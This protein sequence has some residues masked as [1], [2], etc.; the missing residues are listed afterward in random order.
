[1]VTLRIGLLGWLSAGR[2]SFPD[3]DAVADGDFLGADERT[4]SARSRCL[5][6]YRERMA[7]CALARGSGTGIVRV[8]EGAV[9][10]GVGGVGLA[11]DAVGVDLEQDGDAVPGAAGDL[12]GGHP[13]I[14]P[15]GDGGVAEVV[16]AAG[17]RGG[18]LGGGEHGGPG[19]VP[20]RAVR[21]VLEGAAAGG[22]E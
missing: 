17:E 8:V 14:E 2:G 11:V 1:M 9:D 21:A 10:A 6:V 22:A 19:G 16:G 20:D 4:H 15:H 18:L 7:F 13:G 12:G 5:P 3:G